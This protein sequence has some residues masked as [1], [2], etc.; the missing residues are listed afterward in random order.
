MTPWR[1]Y[2]DPAVLDPDRSAKELH[3]AGRLL[4]GDLPFGEVLLLPDD[5]VPATTGL[6]VPLVARDDDDTVGVVETATGRSVLDVVDVDDSLPG[7]WE[8]DVMRL[9][10]PLGKR[11]L[12]RAFA[13]GYQEGVATMAEQPL[14]ARHSR[15]SEVSARLARGLAGASPAAAEARLVKDSAAPRLRPDEVARRWQTSVAAP[16]SDTAREWAQYRETVTE[17]H[18]TLLAHYAVIEALGAEDGRLMVLAGRGRGDVLLLEA[19]P[20]GPST[21]EPRVGAWRAGSDIQRVLLSR[22][23]V[24]LAPQ[25]ML[26]WSTSPDGAVA[27]VW[28]R[29]RA[30]PRKGAGQLGGARRR[31]H[32]MGVVLGLI[33]GIGGDA[34]MLSGYLGQSERFG[35]ALADAVDA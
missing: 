3:R 23:T 22:E 34:H 24:P 27:R 26:G 9:A 5:D 4:R 35:D 30:L 7:P 29:A 33:H 14:H 31:A 2:A 19:M 25:D 28:A 10:H 17:P 21:L 16:L 12:V 11:S 13:A 32:V 15:A 8:W 6:V 18:A 1:M 20:V